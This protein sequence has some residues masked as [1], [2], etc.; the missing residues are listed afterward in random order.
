NA[1]HSGFSRSL[2]DSISN[3][4]LITSGSNLKLSD[5][6]TKLYMGELRDTALRSGT[7]GD[8]KKRLEDAL[9]PGEP[10]NPDWLE[11]FSLDNLQTFLDMRSKLLLERISEIVGPELDTDPADVVDYDDDDDEQDD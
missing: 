6:P 9:I 7:M 8:L 2:L 10:D 1:K 5:K 4:L 11:Q 3:K